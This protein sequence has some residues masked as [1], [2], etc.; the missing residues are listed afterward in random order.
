M[1]RGWTLRALR[2]AFVGR[3]DRVHDAVTAPAQLQVLLVLLVH[4]EA[5]GAALEAPIAG[6]EFRDALR[7]ACGGAP[8]TDTR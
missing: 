8:G 2:R 4:V 7:D 1:K 3:L 6:H 5:R